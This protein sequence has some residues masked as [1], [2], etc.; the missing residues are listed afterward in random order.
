MVMRSLSQLHRLEEVLGVVG[1][2]GLSHVLLNGE[3]EDGDQEVQVGEGAAPAGVVVPEV[4][5]FFVDA[6]DLS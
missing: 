3:V 6:P 4:L 5:V 2:A 1:L